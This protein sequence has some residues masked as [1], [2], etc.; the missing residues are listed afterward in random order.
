[1]DNYYELFNL[2]SFS[3]L[4]EVK[5]CYQ[6]L[7]KEL[8][9]DKQASNKSSETKKE[10]A[11]MFIKITEAWTVLKHPATKADYDIKLKQ[12][13]SEKSYSIND[14]LSLD[15]F[16]V[17]IDDKNNCKMYSYPCRCGG[18]YDLFCTDINTN[19]KSIILQCSTCSLC[20]ETV[21]NS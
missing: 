7:A 17:Y 4:E 1:M 21:I 18:T 5:T 16:E 14:V 8:H 9:P 15:E 10:A 2:P 20:V 3:T 19:C 12:S 13:E 6:Q 11:N